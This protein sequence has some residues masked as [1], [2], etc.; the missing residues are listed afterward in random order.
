MNEPRPQGPQGMQGTDAGTA[1]SHGT[2]MHD[3]LDCS[4]IVLRVFEYIDKETTPDD[5]ALI[6]SHLDGCAHCLDEYERDVLLKAIVRRS[7]AGQSAPG[8]LRTRILSRLTMVT[9]ENEQGR[10]WEAAAAIEVI[11]EAVDRWDRPKG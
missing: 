10:S 9:V 6:R 1:A 11:D 4:Q 8:A 3:H 7:C 5:T 2:S